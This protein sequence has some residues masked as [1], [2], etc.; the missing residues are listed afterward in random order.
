MT[1]VKSKEGD[2]MRKFLESVPLF[3]L[4]LIMLPFSLIAGLI[5]LGRK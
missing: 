2:V 1:S 4:V 3:V 5:D